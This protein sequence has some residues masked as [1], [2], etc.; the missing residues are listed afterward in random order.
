LKNSPFRLILLVITSTVGCDGGPQALGPSQEATSPPAKEPPAVQ[1]ATAEAAEVCSVENEV[2]PATT[3]V[4]T[5]SIGMELVFIPAGEFLMGNSKQKRR[6]VITMPFY[7]GVYEVTQG[8]YEQ[9]MGAQPWS[10]EMS[11]KEGPSYPATYVNWDDAVKFCKR[12]S[13]K[14]GRDYRLP[15]EA[16]WEYACRDI[17]KS[18][19]RRVVGRFP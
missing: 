3:A 8:E 12:L 10:G 2:V 7:L 4:I 19:V 14:E 6:V 5:N 9:V 1:T 18:C 17:V 11:V 13:H 16:E 15:T